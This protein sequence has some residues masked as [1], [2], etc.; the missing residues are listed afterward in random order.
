MGTTATGTFNVTGWDE[1]TFDELD[2]GAKLT[3]AT[4]GQAFTGDLEADVRW[5]TLM[6]YRGDG[7]AVITGLARITG[8]LGGRSGSFVCLTEGTY[9]GTEARS[10]W[11]I[12]EGSGTGDLKG[13][14][15]EGTSAAT[16]EPPGHYTLT[17]EL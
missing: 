14:T 11:T 9:D 5:E 4:I 3:R 8:T 7:T 10:T 15:G 12:V 16:S 13:M 1:S 6:G 2:D 17:Y